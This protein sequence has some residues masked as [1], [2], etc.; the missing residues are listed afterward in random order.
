M[1]S[2]AYFIPLAE[3]TGRIIALDR[4]AIA[5]AVKQGTA[6]VA[7]G[8]NGWVSVNLS[9]RS[10]HDSELPG[11]IQRTLKAQN[12]APEH[13]VIE[14]T[15]SAAMR[16]PAATAAVLRALKEIGVI[17]AVD[18][19]GIGHSSLA[20]L[21]HFPVDLLKLDSSFIADLGTGAKDEHLLEIM[22][23]LAH[24]IGA[25]VVAEGVERQ[26]QMDWLTQ[27]GCDFIQGYLVG[28]P[29]APETITSETIAPRT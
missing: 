5:T 22:I 15:E 7:Q 2:P 6:W 26:E 18:D 20:Y 29:T 10:L 11:Y 23:G 4:W 28:R 8:W 27:A 13:L 3:R 21:K 25:R 16:D 24:R 9:A 12:L 19:F 1:M 17:I 14:V